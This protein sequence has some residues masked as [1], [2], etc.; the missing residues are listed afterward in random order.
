MIIKK[1]RF[2]TH[3]GRV[4]KVN[5]A[6]KFIQ[7]I[8]K[9]ESSANHN[10]SA[11]L[12]GEQNQY[13]NAND[14]G[15][16]SGTA[17]IPILQTLQQMQVQ[18]VVAVVTRYFGGIKLGSGG[19]IRAYRNSV[20]QAINAVGRVREIQQQEL[21]ITI[22]YKQLNILHYWL[23]QEKLP[24]KHTAYTEQVTVTTLASQ[25]QV[26][27]ITKDL[28]NLFHCKVLLKLGST[29]FHEIPFLTN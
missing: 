2:I 25:N 5:E 10:C 27:K 7:K 21:I 18:N 4:K 26:S 24:I 28:N 29:T 6:K 12:I 22:T 20:S 11:Y 15:E 23:K 9:Q 16:P 1:S 19:L 14:N 17:G 3:L 8:K 13:Q